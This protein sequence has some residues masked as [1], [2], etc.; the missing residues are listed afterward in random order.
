MSQINISVLDKTNLPGKMREIIEGGKRG[1]KTATESGVEWIVNDVFLGQEF[2]GD[3]L[4]PDVK[5]ETKQRKAEKGKTLVGVD[6]SNLIHTFDTEYEHNGLTGIIT[7]G[8]GNVEAY[9]GRF[10]ER[11]QVAPLFMR[12]RG[13][14]SRELIRSEIKKGI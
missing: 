1:V 14:K 12:E 3:E 6:T 2:V 8:G 13:E 4:F 7:G 10:F 9:S 5:P 11:W